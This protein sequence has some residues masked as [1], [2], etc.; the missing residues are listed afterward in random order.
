MLI[1]DTWIG[2]ERRVHFEDR[3][4]ATGALLARLPE[5]T[6]ADVD[7]AVAAARAA[8]DE[9]TAMGGERRGRLLVRLADA[10]EERQD[11]IGT[12]ESTDN[13]RPRRE[14]GA[15]ARMVARWYRYFGGLAD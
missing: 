3:D 12:L 8:L 1:G 2:V 11:H 6:P 10:L 13:G 9:W 4:P 15:Q 5:A 14:T 7:R